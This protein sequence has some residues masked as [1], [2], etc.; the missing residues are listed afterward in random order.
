[1]LLYIVGH[2]TNYLQRAK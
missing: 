2:S 1:M